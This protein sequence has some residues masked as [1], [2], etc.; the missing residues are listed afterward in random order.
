[1]YVLSLGAFVFDNEFLQQV[2]EA[3]D[4]PEDFRVDKLES[5]FHQTTADAQSVFA[6]KTAFFVGCLL[7]NLKLDGVLGGSASW[8]WVFLPFYLAV[9]LVLVQSV[10]TWKNGLHV[11]MAVFVCTCIALFC[12]LPNLYAVGIITSF[13]CALIPYYI[14]A[15]I[16]II[17]TFYFMCS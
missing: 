2:L 13:A 8:T 10:T 1:M 12:L 11:F 6:F 7:A 14:V 9:V 17:S 15:V 16:L 4:V 5:F 3:K